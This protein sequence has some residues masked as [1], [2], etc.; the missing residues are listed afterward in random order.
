MIHNSLLKQNNKLSNHLFSDRLSMCFIHRHRL[1]PE[2]AAPPPSVAPT[3]GYVRAAHSPIPTG[4]KTEATILIF[5]WWHLLKSSGNGRRDSIL[6]PPPRRC[7]FP[8]YNTFVVNEG[9]EYNIRIERCLKK[10]TKKKK[11]KCKLKLKKVGG[12]TKG[13]NYAT[14]AT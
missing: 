10:S 14:K 4:R 8:L 11:T 5:P 7:F 9:N 13:K 12:G 2:M 1:L 3:C 6:A